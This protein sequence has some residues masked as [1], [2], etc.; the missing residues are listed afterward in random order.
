MFIFYVAPYKENMA[1]LLA[2]YILTVRF[3]QITHLNDT[4]YLVAYEENI[5]LA[6]AVRYPRITSINILAT[7]YILAY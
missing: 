4:A 1:L 3:P 7:F 6:Q 2:F 5:V